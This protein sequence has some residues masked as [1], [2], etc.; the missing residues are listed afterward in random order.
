MFGIMPGGAFDDVR[1]A[2]LDVETTG[3]NPAVDRVIEVALFTANGRGEVLDEWST[4][5]HPDDRE[6]TGRLAALEQAPT[7]AEVAGDLCLRMQQGV[8]AGHNVTFDLRMIDAELGRLGSALPDLE[9]F[10]THTVATALN[11][12]TP[13]RSLAVL[14]H[15]LGVP[16]AQWHTAA[17]D[18]L[19]TAALISKLLE[20]A[21][22]WGH[23]NLDRFCQSWT[24]RPTWPDIP[25]TGAALRRDV[26]VF[27]P[28]GRQPD[29]PAIFKPSWRRM[30]ASGS[31]SNSETSVTIDLS[32]AYRRGVV[33]FVTDHVKELAPT[34]SW[35]E[36]WPLEWVTVAEQIAGGDDPNG[37][38]AFGLGS[39]L[40]ARAAAT[41]ERGPNDDALDDWWSG[42]FRGTDGITRLESIVNTLEHHGGED[43]ILGEAYLELATMYR[44]H[45]G[46][47]DDVIAT[48]SR[49]FEAALRWCH[50][51]T[52]TWN[53]VD[54]LP[55][56][57]YWND[58]PGEACES[59][60]TAWWD[61]LEKRRAVEE[62][63]LLHGALMH[64]EARYPRVTPDLLAASSVMSYIRDDEVPVAQQL[65]FA[66]LPMMSVS[67]P[68]A[69]FARAT[70]RLAN[71]L[72]VRDRPDD[73]LALC[74]AAWQGGWATQGVPSP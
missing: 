30:G 6:L 34:G 73:A 20:R 55:D 21:A 66:L 29:N 67:T 8:V 15:E 9:Y 14:C 39:G 19:A 3:L 17:G 51:Q 54:F 60:A 62:L 63:T 23:E 10:D 40:L 64:P 37:D 18:V 25:A 52:P 16:F 42:E 65:Y 26:K 28:G 56:G 38:L 47:H 31:N 33:R 22:G 71:A 49:A 70:E 41:R 43:E 61:Y 32:E 57:G 58:D 74:N 36:D 72:A 11:V 27:P 59:V 50:L 44:R 48:Y 45:G 46:R 53:E 2:V 5:V 12:D 69:D 7:F 35:P 1:F 4:L 13:N 24:G 68:T